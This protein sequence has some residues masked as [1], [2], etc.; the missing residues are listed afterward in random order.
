MTD[1]QASRIAWGLKS[2]DAIKQIPKEVR[3]LLLNIA[4]NNRAS[5]IVASDIIEYLTE[6]EDWM[7]DNYEERMPGL[8]AK[9]TQIAI[10][11]L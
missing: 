4:I 9:L 8:V 7:S 1:K 6:I 10:E 3:D 2:A 5:T 11:T